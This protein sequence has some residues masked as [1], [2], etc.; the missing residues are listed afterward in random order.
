MLGK[1]Y[2]LWVR[3]YPLFCFYC[4]AEYIANFFKNTW[5]NT[6]FAQKHDVLP[7]FFDILKKTSRKHKKKD[8]KW[9]LE[10]QI[11]SFF[12]QLWHP[13]FIIGHDNVTWG[14]RPP[15]QQAWMRS[16]T[17]SMPANPPVSP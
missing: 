17:H 14:T 5:K 1:K 10:S 6:V 7:C 11:R 2:R 4:A 15:K 9:P 12:A 3:Q 13:I 8:R 16:G